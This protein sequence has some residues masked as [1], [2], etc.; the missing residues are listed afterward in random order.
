MHWCS[1]VRWFGGADVL[2]GAGKLGVAFGKLSKAMFFAKLGGCMRGPNASWGNLSKLLM[3]TGAGPEGD[4][5][6]TAL[7]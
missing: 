2:D 1:G 6:W 3:S 5:D 7:G 4:V